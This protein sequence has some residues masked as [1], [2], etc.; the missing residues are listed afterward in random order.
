MLHAER[1]VLISQVQKQFAPEEPKK[2]AFWGPLEDS[3]PEV[4]LAT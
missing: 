1:S 4:P 3:S 2:S